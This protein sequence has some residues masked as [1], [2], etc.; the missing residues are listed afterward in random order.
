MMRN[1]SGRTFLVYLGIALF[2]VLFD[3]I[4]E[5]FSYGEYSDA[6]RMMF[7]FP[8]IGG[9]LPF[10]IMYLTKVEI[11]VCRVAYN[12]W[13]S[14]ISVLTCGCLIKGI[15]EISGRTTDYDIIY[16]ILGGLMLLASIF[17]QLI[18]NTVEKI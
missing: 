13:N 16:W 4:Y 14:G 18:S 11:A 15:I 7:F 10:L 12:L 8:L 1:K 5:Q 17:M 2:C 9:T 3:I 6:M